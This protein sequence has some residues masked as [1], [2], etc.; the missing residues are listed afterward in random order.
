MALGHTATDNAETVLIRIL[1]GTSPLGLSGIPP[2]RADGIVRPLIRA[3]REE[4]VS[5]LTGNRFPY[6][7][8]SS[9]RDRRFFRNRVR[10]ELVPFLEKEFNPKIL[11]ALNRLSGLALEQG[12][13][14]RERIHQEIEH[15]KNESLPGEVTF[16][17]NH[18]KEKNP[19]WIRHLLHNFSVC[20]NAQGHSF[21]HRHLSALE[22]LIRRN[23]S[24]KKVCLPGSLEAVYEYGR[25]KIRRAGSSTPG[26]F[27]YPLQ[28][29][30]RTPVPEIGMSVLTERVSMDEYRKEGTEAEWIALDAARLG[31]SPL[32][33]SKRPGDWIHPL[34]F[35]GTKKLK[36]FF[37]DEK[38]PRDRREKTP[39]LVDGSEVLW[40]PGKRI[41]E[42]VKLTDE[43]R[44]VVLF[45]L[46]PLA[47]S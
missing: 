5:Y 34:G 22:N 12:D 43:T 18:L 32:I 41:S 37:I 27:S 25:I 28:V 24:G 33:R 1:R 31:D 39:L 6:R 11:D 9:N 26:V 13:F 44:Q 16:D 38:I 30:G 17:L 4:V 8:D 19:T 7:S 35:Q 29:P 14:I 23:V 20:L 45:Y 21:G 46:E 40:I 3:T 42:R 36:K 10:N 15:S 2:C 47:P